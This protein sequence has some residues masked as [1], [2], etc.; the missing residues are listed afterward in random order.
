[1]PEE[2]VTLARRLTE[3]QIA[4]EDA[5]LRDRVAEAIFIR[6]VG[7]YASPTSNEILASIANG[8]LHAAEVFVDHRRFWLE[9]R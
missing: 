8:A 3:A 9:N 4:T 2:L 5:A 6:A 1:M 7:N